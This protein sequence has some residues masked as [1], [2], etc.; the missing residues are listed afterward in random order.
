MRGLIVGAGRLGRTLAEDLLRAGHDVRLLDGADPRATRLPAAL[1]GCTIHGSPLQRD[2]LAGAVAGCDGLAAV[3]DDDAVNAVVALAARRELRVPMA[4]AVIGNRA[5]AEALAGSGVRVVCPTA[6]MAHELQ[7]MLVGTGVESELEL[8]G[9][10]AL[11][12]FDVPARLGGRRLAELERR[13]ELVPVA[14]ERD[15]GVL[16]ATPDLELSHG[17]VLHVA[18]SHHDLVTDL[19]HP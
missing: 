2:V 12:R 13:G 17:D 14:V 6:R 19:T 7:L 11:Y 15:G 10:T 8:A 5:R 9:Q 16:L 4:I 1:E 3:T 18:A